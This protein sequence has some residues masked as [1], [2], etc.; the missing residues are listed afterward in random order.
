M[1]LG[2]ALIIILFGFSAASCYACWLCMCS[3]FKS[4]DGHYINKALNLK[5]KSLLFK[6]KKKVHIMEEKVGL[7]QRVSKKRILIFDLQKALPP[8]PLENQVA[9]RKV[10]TT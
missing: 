1:E 2:T 8:S 5:N 4:F 10:P 9:G 3:D 7:L 6:K